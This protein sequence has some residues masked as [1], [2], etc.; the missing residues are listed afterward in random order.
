MINREG[1]KVNNIYLLIVVFVFALS[2]VAYAVKLTYAYFADVS[3]GNSSFQFGGLVIAE[4]TNVVYETITVENM[5]PGQTIEPKFT[6]DTSASNIDALVRMQI[7]AV[8]NFD[9]NAIVSSEKMDIITSGIE[10]DFLRGFAKNEHWALSNQ[11]LDGVTYAYYV[12]TFPPH[13]QEFNGNIVLDYEFYDND[14]KNATIDLTISVQV[15]QRN[16]AFDT[17]IA[18][19]DLTADIIASSDAWLTIDTD[20]VGGG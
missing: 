8:V 11:S 2:I 16:H 20:G 4:N 18:E 3:S 10:S 9:S 14:M 15:I 19:D 12:G 6:I 5:M 17:E 7:T 13:I 1:K